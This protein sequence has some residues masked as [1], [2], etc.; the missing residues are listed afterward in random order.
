MFMYCI[1]YSSSILKFVSVVSITIMLTSVG[2]QLKRDG[3]R[4]HT[5]GEVKGKLANGVG[6]QSPSHRSTL[7][8]NLVY[9]ALLPLM[10]TPQLLAVNWTDAPRRFKW[11]HPFRRK[12]KSDFCACAITF[13]THSTTIPVFTLYGD[14][15]FHTSVLAS[16]SLLSHLQL[17]LY[18]YYAME[19]KNGKCGK[20]AV[21]GKQ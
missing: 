4:W 20:M 16:L 18:S 6:S 14:N 5:G 2:G 12:T 21:V 11:T 8:R 13:Q 9:P 10:R 15:N 3:T 7:P 17:N 1:Y 19:G